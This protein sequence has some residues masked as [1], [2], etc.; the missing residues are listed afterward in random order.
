MCNNYECATRE[1]FDVGNYLLLINKV[2]KG[3]RAVIYTKFNYLIF[4]FKHLEY[5]SMCLK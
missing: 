1:A 2:S 5:D 3:E 4:N